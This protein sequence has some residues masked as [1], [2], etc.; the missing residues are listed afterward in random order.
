[1]NDLI[2]IIIPIYKVDNYLDS[3]LKSVQ[4]QSYKNFEVLLINDG[5]PDNSEIICL[6]YV[7]KDKRFTY[8]YKENGGVSSARNLGLD[9]AKGE[10]VVFID[11]DDSVEENYLKDF[12]EH[13]VDDKILIIQ[14]LTKEINGTV[15]VNRLGFLENKKY[16]F[17]EDFKLIILNSHILEGF[18]YNKFF[19]NSILQR[20]NIRFNKVIT[21]KEDEI[22][23]LGYYKYISDIQI[24]TS[25]NYHYINRDNSITSSHPMFNSEFEYLSNYVELWFLLGKEI[26]ESVFRN[27]LSEQMTIHLK[28]LLYVTIYNS[29]INQKERIINLKKIKDKFVPYFKLIKK[30]TV[31]K[32][33]FIL[34]E[35]SCFK[36]LDKFILVR[37]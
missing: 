35:M 30:T 22:F 7:N 15:K 33:D 24:L 28:Y 34:L 12:V 10:F 9:N 5:S 11:S 18:V 23:C 32:I 31:Q 16:N 13:Y 29:K 3:C 4:N 36:M 14:D 2:S 21:H 20:N 8:Y 37:K 17:I 27:Y 6:D 1:M 19:I 26:N 25:S